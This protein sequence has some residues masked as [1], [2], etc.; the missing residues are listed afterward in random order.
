MT[1]ADGVR[2]KVDGVASSEWPAESVFP[3]LSV[4]SEFFRAG[5]NGYSVTQDSGRLDGLC[6]DIHDWRTEALSV[7]QAASTL[8]DDPKLFPPGSIQLDHALLMRNA[9][10]SWRALDDVEVAPAEIEFRVAAHS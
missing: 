3:S 1:A 7:T 2:I 4:A 10:H 6:L 9:E 8:Y 5:C